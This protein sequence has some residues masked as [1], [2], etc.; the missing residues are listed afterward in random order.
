MSLRCQVGRTNDREGSIVLP[1]PR[2][3]RSSNNPFLCACIDINSSKSSNPVS[4]RTL[5]PTIPPSTFL[6]QHCYPPSDRQRPVKPAALSTQRLRPNPPHQPPHPWPA[7]VF[8]SLQTLTV[9]LRPYPHAL[10]SLRRSATSRSSSPL[11]DARTLRPLGSRRPSRPPPRPRTPRSLSSRSDALDTST[12]SRSP[13]LRRLRSLSS[14]FLPVCP[15]SPLAPSPIVLF[16][17]PDAC[18]IQVSTSRRSARRSPRS[19]AALVSLNQETWVEEGEERG[20]AGLASTSILGDQG[21][22]SYAPT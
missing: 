5:A 17:D 4:S 8:A 11:L 16:A 9:F 19:K 22:S 12:L 10:Y 14:P 7:N 1:V 13:T 2:S 20:W 6:R 15:P 18:S 3:I 21:P